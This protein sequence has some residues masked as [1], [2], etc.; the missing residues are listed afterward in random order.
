MDHYRDISKFPVVRHKGKAGNRIF[1]QDKDSVR[2]LSPT[3]DISGDE[4]N[5]TKGCNRS[6]LLDE[7]EPCRHGYS[8]FMERGTRYR[9][10]PH[11]RLPLPTAQK[12]DYSESGLIVQTVMI[13]NYQVDVHYCFSRLIPRT[14]RSNDAVKSVMEWFR[15]KIT[16]QIKHQATNVQQLVSFISSSPESKRVCESLQI[17]E[18]SGASFFRDFISGPVQAAFKT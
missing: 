1:T 17:R 4:N 16:V 7:P 12:Q 10:Q 14:Q 15:K 5:H 3:T 6:T 18:R 13:E 11:Q 8:R 2:S 9:D